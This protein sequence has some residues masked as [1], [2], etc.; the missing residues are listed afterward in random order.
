MSVTKLASFNLIHSSSATIIINHNL[1]LLEYNSQR[2]RLI[3]SEYGRNIQTMIDEAVKVEDS[4]QR[5]KMARYIISVMGQLNP[6]LRDVADFKHKLW[7]HLFIM[8][9]F[10][11]EV[12]SPY[13]I[14]SRES[15]DTKPEKLSY[16][17]NHI[18]YRHYGKI[19]E[20]IIEK[21]KTIEDP[22]T[23]DAMTSAVAH[24]L[25]KSYLAWN[26]DSVDDSIIFNDLKTLSKGE[27]QMA[28]GAKLGAATEVVSAQNYSQQQ[29]KK[30]PKNKQKQNK[31]KRNFGSSKPY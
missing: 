17:H 3:I 5:N 8:S 24:H 1:I 9:D 11:L 4:E 7:D 30:F 20:K 12:D 22:T 31:F 28:E 14:P 13:P 6:H 27:L 18:K 10:K 2:P 21:A 29:G 19:V 23:K 16:P 25:K 26:R 15:F